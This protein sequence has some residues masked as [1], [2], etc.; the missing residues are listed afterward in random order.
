M[1]DA[2]HYNQPERGIMVILAGNGLGD[3]SSNPG[4]D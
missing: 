1:L 2:A 3:M 4:R